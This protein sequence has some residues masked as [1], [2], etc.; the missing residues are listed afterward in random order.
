MKAIFDYLVSLKLCLNGKKMNKG[1]VCV[2]D[3]RSMTKCLSNV[4]VTLSS[5][6]HTKKPKQIK[7]TP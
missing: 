6:P 7:T 2:I 1:V 4:H 5:I 3:G